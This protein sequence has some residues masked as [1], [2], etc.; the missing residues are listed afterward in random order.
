MELDNIYNCDCLEGMRAIPDGSVD[1]IVTDVPYLCTSRGNSGTMSGYWATDKARSGKI[2]DNNNIKIE[3]YLP[4]FYRILKEGTH[5]YIMCNHV[6]LTHFLK[7]IDESKFHFTKCLIW[8][9]CNKICGTYY[10]GQFE[11]ILFIRK[12]GDRKVNDCGVGD[13]LRYANKKTK[14]QDGTNLHDSEKPV[15]LMAMLVKQ[16]SNE[17]DTVLDP[18]MGSAS[19][20]IACIREKRHF[21]GFELNKDYYDKACER[22]QNE[23][24]QPTLF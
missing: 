2:F 24:S 22:I 9:K 16:S 11:Y 21:I 5:C 20:A 1:L 19:T 4:E 10:M 13:I 15:D 3:E 17:G 6:N 23:L 7:V 8:D 14:M 12:G 18:F